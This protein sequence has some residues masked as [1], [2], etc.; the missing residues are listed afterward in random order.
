MIYR[1]RTLL[2]QAQKLFDHAKEND[3]GAVI[4]EILPDS[5]QWRESLYPVLETIP[6]ISLAITNQ[7]SCAIELIKT[8]SIPGLSTMR[9]VARDV[10]GFSSA[11]RVLSYVTGLLNAIEVLPY[12]AEED[13]AL[14][15]KNVAL[16]LQLAGDQIAKPTDNGLWDASMVDPDSEVLGII[17][18]AQSLLALWMQDREHFVVTAQKQ[19]LGMCQGRSVLAYYSARAYTTITTELKELH[20][21]LP[22]GIGTTLMGMSNSTGVDDLFQNAAL[23]ASASES[24]QLTKVTNEFIASLTGHDFRNQ[25]ENGE[26]S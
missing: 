20:G 1:V 22:D 18:N 4:A 12:C 8:R 16:I 5:T 17:A 7:L 9:R 11:F 24:I 15:C 25:E 13:K 2:E 26:V 21:N 3:K 6:C 10:D 14:I 19:L 23:L